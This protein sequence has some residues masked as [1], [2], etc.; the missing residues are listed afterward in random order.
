MTLAV[1]V[2]GRN[3]AKHLPTCFSSLESK[4]VV[5]VDSDSTDESVSIAKKAKVVVVRLQGACTAARGRNAGFKKAI[6]KWPDTQYVQFV[7][8]DC[9][10]KKGWLSR[11]QSVLEADPSLGAVMGHLAEKDVT[12]VYHKL[13]QME[14][15]SLPGEA[16]YFSG[17][18]M[19]RASI[20]KQLGGYREQMVAGEDP[21]LSSRMRLEGFHIEKDDTEMAIH[22]ADIQTFGQWFERVVRS[23]MSIAES[24][25][26]HG[27]SSLRICSK[28]YRSVLFWG[29]GIP[30]LFAL[31][32][33]LGGSVASVAMLPYLYLTAKIYHHRRHDYHEPPADSLLWA[34]FCV[35]AKFPQ[36]YGIF[37]YK[38]K[39][40][41]NRGC[42]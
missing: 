20:F 15:K 7:D 10:L 39:A 5:Y 40:F 2:I 24:F 18:V 31:I 41:A 1:V 27:K 37:R 14:W 33:F 32:A 4:R 9:F 17:V 42:R 26:L 13:C 12:S 36:L 8:G 6:E 22:D 25:A 30:A 35:W 28:E 19:V 21:E 11:G 29:G 3:E 38:L 34:T 23:G 16:A